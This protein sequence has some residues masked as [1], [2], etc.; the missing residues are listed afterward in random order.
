MLPTVVRV[1]KF[2]GYPKITPRHMAASDSPATEQRD[3]FD[4]V[5]TVNFQVIVTFGC[6]GLLQLRC[7]SRMRSLNGGHRGV[8]W[9]QILAAQRHRWVS[10]MS[11][12]ENYTRN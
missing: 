10:S 5:D 3:K 4:T 12:N 9:L 7:R 8:R 1:P 11:L 2:G 6:R